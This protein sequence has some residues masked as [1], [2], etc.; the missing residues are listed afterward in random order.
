MN[1]RQYLRTAFALVFTVTC[2]LIPSGVFAVPN[3]ISGY[4]GANG[5]TCTAC[6][7]QGTA[8]TVTLSP[9]GSTTVTPGSSSSYT[10]TITGGPG[11]GAGFDVSANGGVLVN[12][13]PSG[14]RV[15]GGE[16]VHN[17]PATMSG[18]TY[19]MSF[20][21]QAPTAA[22]NYTIFAAGMSTNGTGGTGGDGT[23]TTSLQVTVSPPANQDPI[24]VIS[25]PTTGV[26]NNL[27]TFDGSGSSDPDG[28]IAAYDWDFGDQSNGTGAVV[29]HAFAAGTYTVTLMVTDNDGAFTHATL[30][31][32]IAA[33]NVAPVASIS[34]PTNGTEGVAVTFDGTGSSDNDGNIVAYDWDFGDNSAGS[35]PT[36]THV[37]VAGTYTVILTV[38]DNDG[39]FGS[40]MLVI[41]IA[42]ATAPQPPL[43]DAGGPYNGT[44]G[45][46][47]QFDG[48][49]ST[50]PD[51]S[52]ASYAWDFG[53]G[54]TGTGV[55]PVH[56]YTTAGN[57]DVQLTVI[58]DSGLVGSSQTTADIVAVAPPP[59]A[60]VADAG[61]PYSGTVD[62]AVQFDGSG[63]TDPDGSIVSYAWDFGDGNTGTGVNP[64]H[65]YAA[66]GT[67]DVQLTVTDDS[68]DTNSS[69]TTAEIGETTPPPVDPTPPDQPTETDGEALY[70][71]YCVSCHGAKGTREFNREVLGEDARDIQ[72]AID[73]Y[74]DMLFLGNILTSDDIDAIAGYINDQVP[75]EP[76]DDVES[77][78]PD[79]ERDHDPGHS[80]KE[81]DSDS[82]KPSDMSRG[83]PFDDGD[84]RDRGRRSS[85]ELGA[86]AL[87]W[88]VL[89]LAAVMVN[90]R[91]RVAMK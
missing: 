55:G 51:G 42:A 40:A 82:D 11:V 21:W 26:E 17:S 19:S 34:G 83:N 76:D 59:Q 39:A 74:P 81:H 6:H 91:R 33:T 49:A 86:G 1:T 12:T 4:S 3:G 10:L 56:I 48:S 45:I 69:Q 65:T 15:S 80:D 14:V 71:T 52:I 35:G 24:A 78:Y 47:V 28:T 50:D 7:S 61:G 8:P 30:V 89:A 90:R 16:L 25:G 5:T 9:S 31:I 41:D 23:G 44:E 38:T 88:L 87:H 54:N 77:T 70:N 2:F 18:G 53:D 75:P 60:P 58:D 43:A 72:E 68:G 79:H 13:A 46:T 32:D 37:Y 36:A 27:I 62:V 22:G 20:D 57:Y 66:A 63:S 29:S 64:S 85:E 73:E 84:S 67:Y